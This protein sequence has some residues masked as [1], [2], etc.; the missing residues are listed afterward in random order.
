MVDK[1]LGRGGSAPETLARGLGAGSTETDAGH[2]PAARHSSGETS[3]SGRM[4]G[5]LSM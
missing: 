5:V 4:G 3:G 2:A 1:E